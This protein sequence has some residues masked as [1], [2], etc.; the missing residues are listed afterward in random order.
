MSKQL[1]Q[2][3]VVENKPGAGGTIGEAA[4]A[5]ADPDGY[6]IMVHSNSHTLT[7]WTY[8]NL[9]YDG[10]RDLL[11]VVPLASVPMVL[12]T[13]PET[14]YRTLADL[15]RAGKAKPD[16]LDYA[17]SGAGGA[18]HLGA[19]RLRMAAGF[20]AT[21][22][23]YKGSAEAV[24]EVL[25][26]RVAFHVA[27]VALALPYIKAGKLVALASTGQKRAH[28]LPDVPTAE[29]AGVPN[30]Y[31]DVWIGM[32]VPAKTPRAIVN[33]LAEEATKAVRAPEVRERFATLSVDEMPMGV[34]EF[35]QFLVRDFELNR[36]LVQATGLEPS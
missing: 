35:N 15:V 28:D 32:F 19:E 8:R 29:E 1:G 13:A 11:G 9:S 12:V 21:H 27:P 34:D 22:I 30:A 33:R 14:G 10:R 23:P 24:R 20:K 16:G 25:A 2:P 4:T 31:Y 5:Q 7:P 18:T 26:G 3:I 17:S 6:T 36:Q